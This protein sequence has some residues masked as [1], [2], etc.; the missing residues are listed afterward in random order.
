MGFA[1]SVEEA[2]LWITPGRQIMHRYIGA[3]RDQCILNDIFNDTPFRL[4]CAKTNPWHVDDGITF[5]RQI[6]NAFQT[7]P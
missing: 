6:G 3:P 4:C 5:Q 2:Q 1:I 7:D